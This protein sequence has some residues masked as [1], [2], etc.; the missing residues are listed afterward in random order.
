MAEYINKAKLMRKLK[1]LSTEAY[2]FKFESKM[3]TTINACIDV[4][5]FM[6]TIDIVHCKDCENWKFPFDGF[7]DNVGQCKLTGWLCGEQGY[8][9]YGR[10]KE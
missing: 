9:M 6:P 3:E 1:K 4:V 2:Q 5:D 10:E 7:N 8:C